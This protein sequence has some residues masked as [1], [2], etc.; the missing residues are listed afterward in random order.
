[1]E[2]MGVVFALLGAVF[3]ALF[4]GIGSSIGVGLAGRAASGAVT[5]DSSLFSKVLILQLLAAQKIFLVLLLKGH[6]PH[7]CFLQNSEPT[8]L[9]KAEKIQL[10]VE[11]PSL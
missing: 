11:K 8:A 5:E 10:P 3:S 9:V 6:I 1:M 4:A 2:N 7:K